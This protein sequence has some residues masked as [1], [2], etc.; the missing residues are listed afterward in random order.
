MLAALTRFWH[1]WG[2]TVME[3][4]KTVWESSLDVGLRTLRL[5]VDTHAITSHFALPL[6]IKTPGGLVVE[7][8]ADAPVAL[9]PWAERGVWSALPKSQGVT[10]IHEWRRS[11]SRW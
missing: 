1:L 9:G 6:L 7:V 10:C 11:R 5:G 3:W 8:N 4:N 2:A